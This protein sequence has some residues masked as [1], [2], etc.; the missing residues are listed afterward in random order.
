M[1]G[2]VLGVGINDADYVVKP[3]VDGVRVCCPFYSRWGSMLNRCYSSSF[4]KLKPTYKDC[5]VCDEWLVFSNFKSWMEKQDWEGKHLDKD[6]LVSGN[7]IYHPDY[8]S[9]VTQE[10]NKFILDGK[11]VRGDLPIGVCFDKKAGKYKASCGAFKSGSKNF[12]GYF[13]TPEEAHEAWRNKKKL[14]AIR[15]SKIESDDRVVAALVNM[16]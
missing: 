9:F 15:L 7:K 14:E 3:I 16:Y 6:I 10:T 1:N 12:A 11:S 13:N 5:S 2:L 8:C 4:H